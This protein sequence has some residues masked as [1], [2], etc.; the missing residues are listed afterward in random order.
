MCVDLFFSRALLLE[1][2]RIAAALLGSPVYQNI[3]VSSNYPVV[4]FLRV[5]TLSFSVW[6]FLV[7]LCGENYI[8]RA[9]F[10][11]AVANT[12]PSLLH[13]HPQIQFLPLCHVLAVTWSFFP[14]PTREPP[15]FCTQAL[16]W[17]TGFN[18]LVAALIPHYPD[19][20][21]FTGTA[22]ESSWNNEWHAIKCS[23]E[24]S[25]LK[26]YVPKHTKK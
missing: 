7:A 2:L 13:L 6:G 11:D 14:P 19:T 26:V 1:S 24:V 3:I 15:W 21:D 18:R 20:R 4:Y 8:K 16:Y 10:H 12:K 5:E 9:C 22:N 17:K 25:W 23:F